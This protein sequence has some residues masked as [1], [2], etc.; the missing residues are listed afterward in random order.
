MG[1]CG[2][3]V[4]GHGFTA[5]IVQFERVGE[6]FRIRFR[7]WRKQP[8]RTGDHTGDHQDDRSQCDHS[9]DEPPHQHAVTKREPGC[10]RLRTSELS[11]DLASELLGAR[12]VPTIGWRQRKVPS[13]LLPAP[14]RKLR[15][16]SPYV[17]DLPDGRATSGVCL[18]SPSASS[19][20]RG[21]TLTACVTKG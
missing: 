19:Q 14:R 15:I 2:R 9:R 18:P 12:I 4:V 17:N 16:R 5:G 1:R 8:V 11:R 3:R 20:S 6:N 7:R 13:F 10:G 21:S